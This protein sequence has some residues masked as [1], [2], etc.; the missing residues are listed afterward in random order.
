MVCKIGYKFEKKILIFF[1]MLYIKLNFRRINEIN[2]ISWIIKELVENKWKYFENFG[3]G[4]CFF[5]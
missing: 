5:R 4:K 1:Y 2:M 3:G